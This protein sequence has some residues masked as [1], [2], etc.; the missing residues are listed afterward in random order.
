MLR[1]V[2]RG[3]AR[4]SSGIPEVQVEAVW[5]IE[6]PSSSASAGSAHWSMGPERLAEALRTLFQAFLRARKAEQEVRSS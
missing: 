2:P 1:G 5:V 3:S 6:R 4:S